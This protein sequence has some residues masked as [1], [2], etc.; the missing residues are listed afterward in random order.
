MKQTTTTKKVAKFL[1]T[2]IVKRCLKKH[3]VLFLSL[4]GGKCPV[5]NRQVA[6]NYIALEHVVVVV[7]NLL[8]S[9]ERSPS[10]D[11]ASRCARCVNHG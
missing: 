7:L 3:T 1:S 9:G 10:G 5:V 11:K 4:T 8:F 2:I 6:N